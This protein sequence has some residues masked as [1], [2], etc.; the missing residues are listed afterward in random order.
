MKTLE[1]IVIHFTCMATRRPTITV[2]LWEVMKIEH[3]TLS[4]IGK[5]YAFLLLLVVGTKLE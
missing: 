2:K 1:A 4:G 5:S 3:G